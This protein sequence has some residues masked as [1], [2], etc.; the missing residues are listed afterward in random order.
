MAERIRE[1]AQVGLNRDHVG[2][3]ADLDALNQARRR[4]PALDRPEL[5]AALAEAYGELGSL[6]KAVRYYERAIAAEQGSVSLKAIEQSANLEG[7]PRRPAGS[8]WRPRRSSATGPS[9]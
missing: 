2:L 1:A 9:P 6:Q 8:A 3:R 5:Q 7:A 4:N